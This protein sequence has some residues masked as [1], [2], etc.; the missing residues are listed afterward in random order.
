MAAT[1]NDIYL[2]LAT[3][4]KQVD[5]VRPMFLKGMANPSVEGKDDWAAFDL[6]YVMPSVLRK[7]AQG[8]RL[9]VQITCYS[10]HAEHRTDKRVDYIY[11]LAET[12]QSVFHQKDILIKTSC[13]N[14]HE[15]IIRYVDLRS[16][17]DFSKQ[18]YQNS[19][20]LHQ[21]AAVLITD[22]LII[23]KE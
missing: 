1:H 23:D 18:I 8:K 12:Y 20:P 13:I 19:P 2:G 10:A 17:S 5:V 15:T 22:G 9:S 4:V 16:L 14:F 11:Q 3:L 6:L 7:S 21:M